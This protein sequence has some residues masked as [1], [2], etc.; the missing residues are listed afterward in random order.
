[1]GSSKSQDRARA[2]F[3]WLK[4]HAQD[5]Q[6]LWVALSWGELLGT[7]TDRQSLLDALAGRVEPK[8]VLLFKVP[9]AHELPSP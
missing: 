4:T 2:N 8:E 9:E 1:M 6:G 7:A 5:Y 3:Q